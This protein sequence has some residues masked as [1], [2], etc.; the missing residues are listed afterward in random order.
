MTV[1]LIGLA[2]PFFLKVLDLVNH[3]S[4]TSDQLPQLQRNLM[5][6][7]QAIE[8]KVIS[9]IASVSTGEW[10]SLKRV[11]IYWADE[12]LTTHFTNWENFVLEQEYYQE[13]NRAWKFFVEAEQC[14]P[15]GSSEAAEF[16]YLAVALG[17][18][19]DIEGAFKFELNTELPGKK[20]DIDEARRYWAAQIQRRIRHESSVDLQDE[21]LEGDV[22]PLVGHG[23]LK[24]ALAA[25]LL[26]TLALV[27]TGGWWLL[28][29]ASKQK[30]APAESEELAARSAPEKDGLQSQV[31]SPFPSCQLLPIRWL[32]GTSSPCLTVMD[33][34]TRHDCWS[35]IL[36]QSDSDLL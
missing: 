6:D 3:S 24:S 16:F 12:I 11:L 31:Q 26:A 14:L 4:T 8:Q 23:I 20:T 34:M 22:E 30:E 32:P 33:S 35:S 13:K 5:A 29:V 2:E 18:K 1:P 27:V 36:A 21:P 7:L 19:G 9:G 25:F 28:E 17:F 15:T 10:Q